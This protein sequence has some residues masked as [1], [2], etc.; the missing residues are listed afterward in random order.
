MKKGTAIRL[1]RFNHRDEK[2]SILMN[3]STGDIV[4]KTIGNT[5]YYNFNNG[6]L[7]SNGYTYTEED[8][9][10]MNNQKQ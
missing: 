2:K 4:V 6:V 7:T 10:M 8:V 5:Y 3:P 1:I 9:K